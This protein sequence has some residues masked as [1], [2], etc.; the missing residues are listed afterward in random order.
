MEMHDFYIGKAFDAY[1]Y[2]GAHRDVYKR[3]VVISGGVD[4]DHGAHPVVA[5]QVYLLLVHSGF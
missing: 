3:Q 2:F 4:V 5:F 1:D